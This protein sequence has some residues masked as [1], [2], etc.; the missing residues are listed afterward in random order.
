M[1]EGAMYPVA[2][3]MAF[4]VRRL[5]IK[6]RGT[7]RLRKVGRR[8]VIQIALDVL[9]RDLANLVAVNEASAMVRLDD[10]A[11]EEILRRNLQHLDQRPE[12]LAGGGQQGDAQRH[13]LVRDR[14]GVV[15]HVCLLI[16]SEQT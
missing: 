9:G 1:P 14:L 12:L 4:P 7:R 11:V 6:R 15:A 3:G 10:H 5:S 16:A 13:S 2:E 8:L